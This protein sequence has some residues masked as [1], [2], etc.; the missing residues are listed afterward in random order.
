MGKQKLPEQIDLLELFMLKEESFNNKFQGT[1][2]MRTKRNGILRNAAVVLSNQQ[3]QPALP[4]LK[5]A[6]KQE[7]DDA[8]KDACIWAIQQLEG[9]HKSNH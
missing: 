4:V 5:M 1:P 2:I 8:V 7:E 3:Y 6:I 9:I